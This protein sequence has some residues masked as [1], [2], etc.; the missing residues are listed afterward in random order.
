MAD[1][2]VVKKDSGSN[3]W[4]W[5]ILALVIV[6]IVW[7]VMARPGAAQ[8]GWLPHVAPSA[9]NAP[10]LQLHVVAHS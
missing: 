2:D 10:H 7:Y 5:V 3:V 1:I 6:A 9:T 4:L 8:A